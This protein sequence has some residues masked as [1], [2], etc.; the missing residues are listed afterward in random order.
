MHEYRD[1]TPLEWGQR[2]HDRGFVDEE[3]MKMI[4]EALREA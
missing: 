4:E 1:V 2:F 3:A